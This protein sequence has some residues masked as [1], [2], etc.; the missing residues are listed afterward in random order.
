MHPLLSRLA[1]AAGLS[2]LVIGSL[3][4]QD[5]AAKKK[6]K[7]AM[8]RLLAKAEEEY[9]VFFKKP[10]TTPEFWAA[11]KFEMQ[12]GK[13][14]L[15]AF[16]LNK[17]LDHLDEEAKKLKEKGKNPEEAY[18][19]LIGIEEVEGMSSFLRL[20]NVRQWTDQPKLQKQ[21]EKDVERLLDRVT[22][23]L[24][25]RLGDP[26]RIQKFIDNLSAP[27]PEERA[28][29][30]AQLARARE[31]AAPQL[32][33]AL[34]K[35][36]GSLRQRRLLE[37][38]VKLEPDVMPPMLEALNARDAKD[39]QDADL[40]L[41]LLELIRR[42]AEK[43]AI[44]YLWYLSAARKYPESVRNSATATLAY[45]LETP[46]RNLPPAKVVLTQMAR[47]LYEHRVKFKDPQRIRIWP[48]QKDYTIAAKPIQ[49][50]ARDYEEVLG[51][52]YARQ[53]L[54]LDPTYRPAQR[55]FL[56][57]TLERAYEGKL[58]QILVGK[59]QPALDQ[60]LATL[61]AG[62][63]QE[64]LE[65]GLADHNL[66]VILPLLKVL[67][68]RGEVRAARPGTSGNPGPLVRALYYPDRRVQFAAATALLHM[69]SEPAPVAAAR[70]VE[71]L[72]R[73]VAAGTTPK[74]LILFAP[75]QK[76][77]ELRKQV[78]AAGFEPVVARDL[79]EAFAAL[80]EA[81]DIDVIL[82]YHAVRES[83]LPYA[84]AQL[85]ADREAGLVPVLFV[86]PVKREAA[87]RYLESRN[88]NVWVLPEAFLSNPAELKNRLE[89]AIKLAAAPDTVTH[90]PGQ[91]GEWLREDVLARPGQK[92]S[93]PERKLL[94]AVAIDALWRMAFGQLKGYDVRPAESTVVDA[95]RNDE[96][97][98]PAI[99][100]LST[101]P[102]KPAQQRLADLVLDAKR[103]KRRVAAALALNR[104]VQK[105]GVV[106]SQDQ[107]TRLRQLYAAPGTDANLRAQLAILMGSLRS[108]PEVTGA[109]LYRFDPNTPAKK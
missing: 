52:R 63:L 28:F 37:A 78:K 8:K 12:V 1:V 45:L 21:A 46:P 11:I 89:N 96:T 9:R 19:D 18:D 53:A 101:F 56:L 38:A 59:T 106:L 95:L 107:L 97:T 22:E 34:K 2:L 10:E 84:L 87:Y 31:R 61:D 86:A 36:P 92:L 99:E 51:T 47:D 105:N 73:F 42:R 77:A 43:R 33:Q 80:H 69:P 91:Q 74:A 17:L 64:V 7:E 83:E 65:R 71:V 44:P 41:P 93:A 14:D 81:A 5:A 55:I 79:K 94:A 25:K 24:D 68:E 58:D 35:E 48:W 57:L 75:D 27:T 85:R 88:R 32:L 108:T 109:R 40:R 50:K 82:L 49:L 90:A 66:A 29:A 70:V 67:G 26:V 62:L 16:H 76:A 98:V 4:A 72:R 6:D 104:H 3:S 23:A 103:G 60:L 15:A 102:G 39:A 13:Y 54:D 20:K 30:F 100:L